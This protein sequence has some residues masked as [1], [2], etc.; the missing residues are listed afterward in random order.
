MPRLARKDLNTPFLHVMVQGIN[1]EYIFYN[2]EYI[3]QYLKIIEK[4]KKD[5]NFTIIA[6]CIMNNHAH[7]LVYTEEIQEL[8]K[9]V[10]KTNL[11]YSKMYNNKEHRCGVL[12][13]NKY[14]AEPI[15][16]VKYLA[17]CINYIHQNPVKAGIV[18]KCED[19]KYSS[20]NDYMNNCGATQSNIMKEIFGTQCNYKLIFNNIYES[21]FMDVDFDNE[22]NVKTYI[23]EGIREFKSIYSIN[24]VD[25]FTNRNILKK[26]IVFLKE[27]YKFKYVEIRKFFDISRGIMNTLVKND[28]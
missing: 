9:F 22:D 12:F 16:D 25:I 6:Y 13:R 21:R 23:L 4:Y 17:N 19:Y 8:S 2:N 15:Y 11:V 26:L 7:F 10:Q 24:I 1:K 28:M 18:S 3:K 14:Q 27:N 5:F 20:Y